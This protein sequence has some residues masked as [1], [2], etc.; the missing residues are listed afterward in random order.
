LL[1][2]RKRCRKSEKIMLSQSIVAF[3]APLE[4]IEVPTPVPQGTEVLLKVHHAGVCHSDV[5]IHD[6]YF[7]LGG[8]NKLPLM[9]LRLPHTMGHEIEGE[10]VAL[11]ADAQGVR[12]GARY[13]AFP[14]IG[15]GNCPACAR[16]EENLCNRARQLGCSPG[17]AG[18]YAT[19]VLVPHP[20]YLLDYGDA[21]PALAAAYMCSGLTAFGAMKKMGALAPADQIAVI[22]CGGVG[23]MGIRFAQALTG[24]GPIATD[25]DESRLAAAR[26]AGAV[27][28]Y[29]TS[30]ETAANRLMVET[31]GG[32]FAAVDFVGSEKSF[33]FANG[34]VRKGGRIIVVGLFG[35]SMA[36]PLPM[37]PLR[38]LSITGSF[39]GTLA[40][41]NEM[42]ELV[43]GGKIDPIPLE[44]RPLSSAGKTLDDLRGGRITGRIVLTPE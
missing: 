14:W 19:H 8:G 15:C 21:D 1:A 24:K 29:N 18:G 28:T 20:R 10:V 38:A 31:S 7:D 34:I 12:I 6:G 42:M 36:M 41:A 32:A 3:G 43:R 37:F 4:E 23:L 25:I 40:E 26:D 44:K 22:G 11:G 2:L 33:A 39:V 35:G 16:G 30:D 9:H 5:H 13:A 27:A 17:I